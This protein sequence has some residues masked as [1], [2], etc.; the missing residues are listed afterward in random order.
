[1][2]WNIHV[3]PV[4]HISDN[5]KNML[6]LV[7]VCLTLSAYGVG[8]GSF[9]R[10]FM[11]I[12]ILWNHRKKCNTFVRACVCVSLYVTKVCSMFVQHIVTRV[13]HILHTFGKLAIESSDVNEAIENQNVHWMKHEKLHFIYTYKYTITNNQMREKIHLFVLCFI[14]HPK[15]IMAIHQIENKVNCSNLLHENVSKYLEWKKRT[16]FGI[17]LT[18]TCDSRVP[19]SVWSF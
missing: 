4:N 14:L 12:C 16:F 9:I 15:K 6:G 10:S 1:M 2:S 8:L 19:L 11:I 7:R 18:L 3:Q 13:H 5:V 17:A